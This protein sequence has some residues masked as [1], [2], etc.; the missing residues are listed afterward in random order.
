MNAS[1]L[2]SIATGRLRANVGDRV[3]VDWSK[4]ARCLEGLV[5]VAA[6]FDEAERGHFT[7]A[8]ALDGLAWL[9]S[10]RFRVVISIRRLPGKDEATARA[11]YDKV[12]AGIGVAVET[13]DPERL[14]LFSG[15]GK[16]RRRARD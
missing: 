11:G 3:A 10:S 6:V 1:Y 12:L 2:P 16:D 5:D 7:W 4:T 14:V 8:Q 15:M 9:S 13:N